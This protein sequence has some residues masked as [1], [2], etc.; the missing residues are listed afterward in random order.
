MT[1]SDLYDDLEALGAARR[2]A[3]DELRRRTMLL[4]TAVIRARGQLGAN[5]SAIAR[6]AGVNRM[7]VRKWFGKR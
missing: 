5:E 1:H 7:T 6:E 3:A 2:E 4:R